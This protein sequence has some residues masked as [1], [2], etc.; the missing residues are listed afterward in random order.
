M[1]SVDFR[2][3]VKWNKYR[4]GDWRIVGQ[5]AHTRSHLGDILSPPGMLLDGRRKL[6]NLKETH[7][8]FRRICMD[9]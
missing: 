2:K 5:H 6:E 1:L 3:G 8:G 4:M 9:I 7:V